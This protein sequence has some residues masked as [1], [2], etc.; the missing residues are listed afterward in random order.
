[1]EED[2]S[3]KN[4]YWLFGARQSVLAGQ[5]NTGGRY[6]LVEG[7]FFPG[8]QTPPHRHGADSGQVYVLD[9]AFAVWAGG[10]TATPGRAISTGERHRAGRLDESGFSWPP[11]RPYLRKRSIP[12]SA[13]W[14]TGGDIDG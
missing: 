14:E 8:A 1:M 13:G 6:D 11:N 2:N 10:R 4:A 9:G 3:M 5:A 12:G 7:W